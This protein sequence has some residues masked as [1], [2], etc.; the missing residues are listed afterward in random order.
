MIWPSGI[1]RGSN[2]IELWYDDLD[3]D[4]MD[5]INRCLKEKG[6]QFVDDGLI[7]D[8]YSAYRLEEVEL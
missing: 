8:G 4:V 2:E 6:L 7:H 1:E 5:K 3:E